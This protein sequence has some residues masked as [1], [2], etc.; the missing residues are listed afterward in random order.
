MAVYLPLNRSTSRYSGSSHGSD[1]GGMSSSQRE[2]SVVPVG[3][4]GGG[5][6]WVPVGG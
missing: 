4:F 1:G 6:W 5:A 3:E 2:D